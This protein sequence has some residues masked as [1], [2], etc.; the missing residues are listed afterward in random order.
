MRYMINM[1]SGRDIREEGKLGMSQNNRHKRVEGKQWTRGKW[2][3][4]A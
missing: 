4:S 2:E 3:Q 1:E